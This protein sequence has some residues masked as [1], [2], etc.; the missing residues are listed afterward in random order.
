MFFSGQIL[1]TVIRVE[2]A[3]AVNRP[4]GGIREPWVGIGVSWSDSGARTGPQEIG[5]IA[6]LAVGNDDE[7]ARRLY[8]KYHMELFRFGFHVLHDQGL[9][10]EM[11]QE[12][13]IKFCQRAGSYDAARGPVRAWLFMM[14]RSTA[15]DIARRPSSRP[16]LPVE[17]FQLPP[18]YDTVDEALT[19]LTIDQ[20]IDKLPAI[21]G[22][23]I[24]LVQKGFTH[25]EI[26]EGLGI[27]V[28]TVKSRMA[29]AADTLRADLASLRGG[30]DA[31]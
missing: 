31:L 1:H 29:K 10:E 30:D 26:A 14:A 25:S 8:R 13:F 11:V 5:L 6:D 2:P 18:Q 17:D 24:R 7:A 20:A 19:V 28:G 16:L 27:P 4:G 12:T 23:V 3:G 21:Y 22:N 15:Y 9:A